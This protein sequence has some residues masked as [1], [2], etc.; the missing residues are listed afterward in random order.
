MKSNDGKCHFLVNTD[1]TVN[2]K[3]GNIN[4]TDFASIKLE[5]VKLLS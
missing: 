5:G 1:I 2:S 4:I 3:I